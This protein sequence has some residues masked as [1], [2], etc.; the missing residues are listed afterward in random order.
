MFDRLRKQRA[1]MKRWKMTSREQGQTK[2]PGICDVD[3]E[4]SQRV[5]GLMDLQYIRRE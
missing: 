1:E 2:R 4:V 3:T 5:D